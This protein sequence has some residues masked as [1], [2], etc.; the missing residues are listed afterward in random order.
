MDKKEKNKIYYQK[1]R[2]KMLDKQK[3]YFI[4]NKE[5]VK[6]QV[7]KYQE[8]NK[9]VLKSKRKIKYNKNPEIYKER[10][11]VYRSKIK[12]LVYNHYGSFCKCCGENNVKFLSIDHVNNDGNK[13]RK[14]KGGSTNYLYN[15]IINQDFPNRYQILCFNCNLGKARNNGICPHKDD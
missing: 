15:K 3:L 2:Q 14:T 6:K 4:N 13:E 8:K 7:K 12:M 1:N 10:E 5:K 9:E 11:K